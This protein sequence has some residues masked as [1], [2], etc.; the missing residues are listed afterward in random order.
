MALISCTVSGSRVERSLL[1]TNVH[2]HSYGTIEDSVILPDVDIA[3]DCT[4]RKAIIDG[5][6]NIPKGF[7]V[8]VDPEEDRKRFHVTAKGVTLV[9]PQMLGQPIHY[10]H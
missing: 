1:F 4:I 5:H 2:V 10:L 3:R 6:C 9:T 7:T 8:G